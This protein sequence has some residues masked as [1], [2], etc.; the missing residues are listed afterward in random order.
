MKGQWPPSVEGL[1]REGIE[2][3]SRR[4]V[5]FS[6][7][8]YQLPFLAHVQALDPDERVLGCPKRLEAEHRGV[9]RLI[10]R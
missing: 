1:C 8:N 5:L 7:L 10:A 9:I 2:Q 3:F 6:F 4:E